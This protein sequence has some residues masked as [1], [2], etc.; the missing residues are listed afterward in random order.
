METN[1]LK[2]LPISNEIKI[3]RKTPLFILIPM[4][5]ILDPFHSLSQEDEEKEYSCF[6][7]NMEKVYVHLNKQAYVAGEDM[8]YKS[9]I[10]NAGTL[11]PTQK[12]KI[13]YYEITKPEGEVVRH[14]R[15]NIHNGM[16]SGKISLPDTLSED[17]YILHAYTNWLRN[18]SPAFWYSAYLPVTSL[19]GEKS[20]K[21][22]DNPNTQIKTKTPPV[23]W[24][25]E[26]GKL[27]E[28][29]PNKVFF[30]FSETQSPQIN[31]AWNV[32]NQKIP[33]S[34]KP[35]IQLTTSRE[36]IATREKTTIQLQSE[37][38]NPGEMAYL[39]VSVSEKTPFHDKLINRN[40]E[41]YLRF[42]SELNPGENPY[43]KRQQNVNLPFKDQI[44]TYPNDH[45]S[46][47]LPQNG[48]HD[49]CTYLMEDQGFV[50]S[51]TVRYPVTQN[52][53][54]DA[55]V[56][57]ATSDSTANMDYCYTDS[58]GKFYFLLDP[59]YDQKSIILQVKD[60]ITGNNKNWR[61]AIDNKNGRNRFTP[62]N[63]IYLSEKEKNYLEQSRIISIINTI[64]STTDTTGNTMREKIGRQQTESFY[65]KP[66]NVVYPENFVDLP[67][68]PTIVENI[69]PG[70]RFKGN[71]PDYQIQLS[72]TKPNAVLPPGGFVMLNGIPFN[73]LNYI[74]SLGS[75]DIE[76]I[77]IKRARFL[78]GNLSFPGIVSI[79]THDKKL[80]DSYLTEQAVIY[81]N[82]V[83]L[84][85]SYENIN[86]P[87]K[88]SNPNIPDLRQNLYWNPFIKLNGKQEKTI[89]LYS[90]DLKSD[91]II[92]VQGITNQGVPVHISKEIH[93]K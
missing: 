44:I 9:Y 52:P 3:F 92:E 29:I 62:P 15:S 8:H 5:L 43:L 7:E 25:F 48:H 60:N 33:K 30:R 26:G 40:I 81:E 28:G 20:N 49:S 19:S 77:E 87:A 22:S 61:V 59:Y 46:W 18:F 13:I 10:V 24:Y 50:L 14:W 53:V 54:P 37:N 78:Y 38:L 88:I 71:E 84:P 42:Y 86:R 4:L 73:D 16:S 91:Y 85:D 70:V 89:E 21:S 76:R 27:T 67:D 12:S 79:W 36:Q 2:Y 69:L 47:S 11:K 82:K 63:N 83:A 64:F 90:S 93:V 55:L 51:G 17:I 66:D 23:K 58:S 68:F 75:E 72:T 31:G 41:Q 45:Y 57:M 65:G 56:L 80:P 34:S 6:K 1:F 32:R 74:A 39:S 35:K